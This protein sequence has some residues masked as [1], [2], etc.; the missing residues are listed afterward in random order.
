MKEK[1]KGITLISL[2]ITIIILLILAG[3]SILSLTKINLFGQA[4]NAKEQTAIAKAEEEIKLVLNE[5]KIEQATN[6]SIKIEDFLNTKANESKKID[7][8]EKT[9][10]EK[11]NIYKDQYVV[12][13]NSKGDIIEGIQ[14]SG[15]RPVISNI[16]ITTNG[17]DEA[18]DNSIKTGTKLQINF[19]SSINNGTIKSIT[20]EVPYTT[21]GTENEKQFTVVGTINGQ[22]YSKTFT[23]SVEN[24]YIKPF[25]GTTVEEAIKYGDVLN[26]NKNIELKDSK[27]NKI[28]IPAGFKVTPD[29]NTVDKGIV[30]EDTTETETNGSQFVWI[31]VGNITKADGL[32]T[33][34]TLENIYTGNYVEEDKGN[35]TIELKNLGNTISKNITNFKNS[36]SS[37]GG[38]YIGRYEA[39]QNNGKITEIKKNT[40]WYNITQPDAAEKSQNMYDSKNFT[41]DLMNSYAW[42]TAI[43]FIQKC[44]NQTNYSK[45]NS[46]NKT[47]E[48]TGTTNDIQCNIF[49][50]ASNLYE[51]TTQ[52]STHSDEPCVLRGGSFNDINHYTAFY[53]YNKNSRKFSTVGFRPILYINTNS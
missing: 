21:N 18:L 8:F 52:T 5:W 38:Y 15:P 41:S 33:N 16:K 47:I 12:V 17:I 46:L 40:V 32:V 28:V 42:D 1:N 26:I 30:I 29:A 13:I 43:T 14:K 11:Y 51:W 2:I 49:D 27:N 50:M 25:K 37:N 19:D 44:T 7:S 39:R 4:K 53:S 3:I 20:P 10:D 45:Q 34:I 31:P 6:N 36:T 24:K 35:T 9:E 22:D 48:N 23:V